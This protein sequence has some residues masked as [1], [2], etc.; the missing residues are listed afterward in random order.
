MTPSECSCCVNKCPTR[1]NYTQ[2]ILSLNCCTCFGWSLNPSSIAQITV[3]TASGTSQPLLLTVA[4]VEELRLQSDSG[5]QGTVHPRSFGPPY[6]TTPINPLNAELNPICHLLEFLGAHYILHVSMERFKRKE[7]E[8]GYK[9]DVC[10]TC[11]VVQC[12]IRNQLDVT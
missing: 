3:S 9:F 1:Y 2:F 7:D 6:N 8:H 4:I 12:G 11:S 10:L 5:R